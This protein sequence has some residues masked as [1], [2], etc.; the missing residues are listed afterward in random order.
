[1]TCVFFGHRDCGEEILPKL[2]QTIEELIC[3]RG[4]DLFYVGNNGH[5]DV[6]VRT[7]LREMKAKYPHIRY[8]VA[9]AYLNGRA[10]PN[11][12]AEETVFPEGLESVHPRF[13]LDR[14]NR[15][16]VEQ[17]DILVCFVNYGFGGAAK[18]YRMALAK[19]KEVINIGSLAQ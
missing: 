10:D 11:L 4:A 13:A 12:T 5:F 19:N 14:R 7:V 8:G 15:W 6:M 17:A 9:V 1:M 16:M 3:E 18:F 2:R